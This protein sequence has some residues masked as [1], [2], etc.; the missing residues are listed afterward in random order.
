MA[1]NGPCRLGLCTALCF[2]GDRYFAS[3]SFSLYSLK[4]NLLQCSILKFSLCYY[5]EF[6]R[7]RHS[8]M[9][10]AGL[11]LRSLWRDKVFQEDGEGSPSAISNVADPTGTGKMRVKKEPSH[12]SSCPHGLYR[13][14]SPRTFSLVVSR[15]WAER[16]FLKEM[17]SLLSPV[18]GPNIFQSRCEKNT[19]QTDVIGTGSY[20]CLKC[21]AL[22]CKS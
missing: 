21:K 20:K 7:D 8:L 10:L 5:A 11:W 22:E 18:K 3:H 13:L 1:H 2:S 14:Q 15:E 9:P 19:G 4:Q 16:L 17:L 6:L 12:L